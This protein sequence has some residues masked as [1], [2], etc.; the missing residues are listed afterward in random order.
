MWDP[1]CAAGFACLHQIG[2]DVC[3]ELSGQ[4]ELCGMHADCI[5]TDWAG[6]VAPLLITSLGVGVVRNTTFRNMQLSVEIAD[7]SQAGAVHFEGVGLANVTLAKG[8]IVGTTSSDYDISFLDNQITYYAEDDAD[9]DVTPQPVPPASRGVFAEDF[10]LVN[11]TMSDCINLL[12]FGDITEA[13]PGCGNVSAVQEA[14][15]R[16]L[17]RGS[18]GGY[19]ASY[20]GAPPPPTGCGNGLHSPL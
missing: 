7:V 20:S 2:G 11:E 14:R 6:D 16:V 18:A 12:Y 5:V 9:F 1:P 19:A 15:D 17:Q 13:F 3:F 4:D 10:V 8:A